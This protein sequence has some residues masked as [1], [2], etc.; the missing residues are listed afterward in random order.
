MDQHHLEK[1]ATPSA[2]MPAVPSIDPDK[3]DLVLH[4]KYGTTAVDD[5]D[6]ELVGSADVCS[7]LRRLTLISR[8]HLRPM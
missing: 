3:E 7:G 1:T 4:G 6:F 8:R 2:M 5:E